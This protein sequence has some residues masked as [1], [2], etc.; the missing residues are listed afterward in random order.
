MKNIRFLCFVL[1]LFCSIFTGCDEG[2]EEINTNPNNPEVINPELLMVSIIRST[3][4]Q[5]V[6]E[7][8]SPGNIVAQFSAEIRDPGTDRYAW[9]S[10][11]TWD[12]GYGVLRNVNNLLEIATERN[13]PNYQGI[14][15]VMRALIFSRMTDAYGDL[16]YSQ[17]LQGK[18]STPIYSPAY[19][20]QEDI[21]KGLLNELDQANNLLSATGGTIRNDILFSGNVTRWK[22]LANSLR[23]RLL[24]RQSNRV[25]PAEAIKAMLADATKFPLM[26]ANADNAVLRY[27]ESPNLY[28]LAGQRSG[29]FLDRRLSKTFADQL[30]AIKDPRLPVFAQ[31]TTDSK[32]AFATGKGPLVYAGVL[33]GDTD[34]NLGSSIDKKVSPLGSIFYSNIQVAVPAQG[35]IMTAAEVNFILAEAVQR[36]WITG[37]AKAYYEAGIRA[38]VDYYRSVSSVNITATNDYLNQAG[39]VYNATK[40]LELIATQKWIALYFNDLQAWHEWK[41]TGIPVLKPSLVNNNGNV[42]PVRFRYP[43]DQ[44][45]TNRN[46][47]TAAV[48]RQG[49]DDINTQVWWDK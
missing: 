29:F 19:D 18:E 41:R 23:L 30:N 33:N 5:M 11:S 24:L 21:Y 14:A 43:T 38:S 16:P 2:F 28:P 31:A 22:R 42:I 12:N 46:S 34:A 47:Y 45:V 17:A 48:A 32:D 44:Q 3:T 35:L 7:G 49:A 40:G 36:G 15:L 39:V 37:D 25:N 27:V 26:T 13:L 9:G 20:K 10:F 4:N 6:N 1:V 8:F